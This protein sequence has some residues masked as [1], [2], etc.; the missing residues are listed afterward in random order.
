VSFRVPAACDRRDF[1]LS[2]IMATYPEPE[3]R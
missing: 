2:G 3:G 1:F